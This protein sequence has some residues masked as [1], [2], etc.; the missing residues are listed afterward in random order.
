M[1][2]ILF[3][4]DSITDAERNREY[5]ESL[6]GMGAGYPHL[7][8]ARLGMD[9]PGEYEFQNRG[10]SGNRIVD[11]YARIKR[12]LINLEPDYL[13]LLIGVN[14]VWHELGEQKN[15]VD[16]KK[17]EMIYDLLLSEVQESLPHVKIMLLEPFV[18]LGTATVHEEEP[19]RWHA[20]S[21]EVPLRAA[22]TKR[23]AEKHG[24]IFVPLQGMFDELTQKAPASHW[25]AD[26]VHPTAMGHE[27]IARAWMKAFEQLAD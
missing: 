21:T 20:F 11:V 15:G 9:F 24:T 19:E 12:D 10:I 22:A 4:G 5:T 14:D 27:A 25:L 18:L 13:S 6:T 2:R 16:A 3:Q 26:G 23:M 17:F 7:L 8:K 1:K